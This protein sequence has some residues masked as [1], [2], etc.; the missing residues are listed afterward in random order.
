MFAITERLLLRPGWVED[1]PT[2][3]AAI[4][5]EAIARNLARVPFPYA[6]EDAEWFLSQPH[7]PLRPT[8]LIFLRDRAELVG[9]IGLHGEVT[10]EL[11]YWIARKHQG[12]GIA[13]EAG[14][15]VVALA[16]QSLRLSRLVAS[17][18]LDNPAS[19]RVLGK[20]GFQPTGRVDTLPS[21][22]RGELMDVRLY[23]RNPAGA[24]QSLAA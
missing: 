10:P 4:G 17:H 13:T 15:A 20:L 3:A 1:A 21:L 19:G 11:G 8:F 22:A 2:L 24:Q 23:S 5:D 18:A 16:D 6:V 7:P 14:Q 9:G 12:R